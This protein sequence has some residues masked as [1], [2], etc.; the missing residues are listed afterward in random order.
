MSEKSLIIAIY[1]EPGTGKTPI[2]HTSPAPRLILD[3]ESG[4]RFIVPEIGKVTWNPLT[5]PIPEGAGETW[6]TCV[7]PT[8]SWAAFKA[9]LEAL[10]SGDHPFRSLV[11]D[12]ITEIQ[13]RCK[14]SLEE[15]AR[16]NEM[17]ERLWGTLL[18][19]MERA[20]RGCR[21]MV[22]NSGLQCVVLLALLDDQKSMRRPLIQGKLQRS[23]P[24]IPDTMAHLYAAIDPTTGER[25]TALQLQGDDTAV[26]KDRT[27]NLPNGGIAGIYGDPMGTPVNL[28]EI[29]ERIYQEV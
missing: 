21:D 7:V 15:T 19:E 16:N 28:T 17:T 18:S 5:E 1:G 12:S 8:T 22:T 23:L 27:T 14:D 11:L 24:S 13:K 3:A 29:I 20:I 4:S 26:A 25:Y 10:K 9:A 2:A 6:D